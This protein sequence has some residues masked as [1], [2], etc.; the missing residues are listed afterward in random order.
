MLD[1]NIAYIRLAEFTKIRGDFDAAEEIKG[2]GMN[3][4]IFELA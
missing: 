1:S 3:K 4:L 2:S